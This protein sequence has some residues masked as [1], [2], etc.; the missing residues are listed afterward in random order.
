MFFS[1]RIRE[2]AVAGTFYP[3]EP[4]RL[5]SVVTLL[6]E[7]ATPAEGRAPKAL[8]APHAGYVYSGPVAASAYARLRPLRGVIRRVLLLG[9]AHRA[10]LD[11]LS[12]PAVDALRTPLGDVPVDREA[13]ARIADLPQVSV[14]DEAHV[15][16]HSLEVHLPFLQVA[17]GAFS[18]VPLVVGQATDD[19][20]AEVLER[21]WG[22]GE[23][24]VVISSD[25]S[26]YHD[27]DTARRLDAATSAAIEGLRPEGL[28]WQSACGRVPVR[29]LLRVAQRRGLRARTLDLRNSGDTAGPRD[30]VVG[31]G[32]WA[33]TE[34][35]EQRGSASDPQDADAAEH[36]ETLL[37]V[38]RRSIEHGLRFGAALPVSAAAFAP[39]LQLP[40]A[41]FVT[42]RGPDRALRGCIGRLT[43]ERPL[44]EDVA[45]N[46]FRAAFH[47]PRFRPVH[48]GE[49][50]GLQ[51]HLSV[52]APPEEIRPASLDHL[53]AWLRPGSDGVIVEEHPYRATFLPD[54]W[55]ELPAPEAFLAALWRKAG[56][57]P[58]YWSADLR[59]W[60]YASRGIG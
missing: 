48:A 43:A 2:P 3:A 30:R 4:R 8:V 27:Y 25:L 29:G 40:G 55:K 9:P 39:A 49:L 41:S 24:L 54:V 26:H 20:V 5:E 52:L 59:V 47:D 6:L 28:D 14:A 36:D 11:G 51:I 37:Q 50:P 57:R 13:V 19:E 53:A 33:F 45:E 46:A 38:A 31:Y 17:L 60:R 42:L 32:A 1:V 12:A 10:R 21:L 18:V 22:G 58:G 56:L 35:L 44:V 34:P 16:E 23:T 7:Q 15:G